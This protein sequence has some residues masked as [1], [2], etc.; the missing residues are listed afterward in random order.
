MTEIVK[1][2][3]N[4]RFTLLIIGDIR[5]VDAG[6]DAILLTLRLDFAGILLRAVIIKG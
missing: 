1:H 3:L 2:L 5:L 4:H 6:I